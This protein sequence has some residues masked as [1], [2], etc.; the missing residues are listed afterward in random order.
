[1]R[2][3]IR[4]WIVQLKRRRLRRELRKRGEHKLRAQEVREAGLDCSNCGAELT[5]PFCHICGQRDDDFKRPFWSLLREILDNVFSS[6]SRL[7]KTLFL[8]VLV[9][10]GLTRAFAMG[11]RAQF[12]PPLRLYITVSIMFFVI[13]AIADVLILDVNVK[14]KDV[15]D[16]LAEQRK[17]VS[18]EAYQQL[19]ELNR[20]RVADGLEPLV[21]PPEPD[22]VPTPAGEKNTT[23]ADLIPEIQKAIREDL[24][25]EEAA[26][27]RENLKKALE[28]SGDEMPEGARAALEQMIADPD[29]LKVQELDDADSEF[30]Y[31]VNVGMFVDNNGEERAGLRQEDIDKVLDDPDVP[32]FIKDATKGLARA[33][34]QPEQMNR[35]FNEWLPR[36]LFVL[37]PVFALILRVF[38]WRKD[39]YILHQLVFSLHFHSFLF[40]LMT[41]LM[42]VV[43]RFGG[44]MGF[45]VFWWGTSLYLIIALKVGQEQGWVR[46]FLKA[47]FIWVSYFAV[48]ASAI[49]GAVLL[50]LRDL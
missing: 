23:A 30:P 3:L 49:M 46:A 19:E 35:L 47:G 26:K 11:R 17:A 18:E 39:R 38:H 25:S 36:A 2:R 16:E 33:L 12:V 43:P 20:K 28:E 50:G 37:V 29:A 8:L 9:P 44:D 31:D 15:P 22:N 34:K 21:L 13:V 32:D 6:D 48:M 41:G 27:I 5:G 14:L 42:I 24:E 4:K 1:M 7:F 45:A 10:G 40:L